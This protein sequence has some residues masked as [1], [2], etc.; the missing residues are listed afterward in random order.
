MTTAP[1][2][3]RTLYAAVVVLVT[4]LLMSTPAHAAPATPDLPV[5]EGEPGGGSRQDAVEELGANPCVLAPFG[6][7]CLNVQNGY[8]N[9]NPLVSWLR[10]YRDKVDPS[11]ICNW[12][13]EMDIIRPVPYAPQ[14]FTSPTY[15]RCDAVQAWYD[16][17]SLYGEYPAN[18]QFCS[19][20][21][22]EGKQQGGSACAVVY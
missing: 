1:N 3:R 7:S 11:L 18:T 19:R 20:W 6:A 9:G 22:E 8:S 4:L 13:A 16:W 14:T 15:D 17:T 2:I 10:S 21:F 5:A 12:R